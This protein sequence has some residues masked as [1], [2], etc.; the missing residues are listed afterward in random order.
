MKNLVAASLFFFGLVLSGF[1]GAGEPAESGSADAP[2]GTLDVGA[3]THL[4]GVLKASRAD[5]S[6]KLLSVKSD[7]LQGD[8]LTTEKDT[9]AR[10]KFND[11]GEIVLRPNTIF[12]VQRYSYDPIQR[13]E[14][15]I[16]VSLIKGGLRSVTGLIGKRSPHKYQMNTPVA[17]IGI[18]G[19]HFGALLCNDDCADIP[20]VA[21][22]TPENGLHTDTVQGATVVSNDRGSVDVPAGAFSYTASAGTQPKLVPPDQGIQITM[23]ASISNNRDNGNGV[24]DSKESSCSVK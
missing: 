3:I 19:T 7:V 20:T 14:D 12:K 15:N 9:Y 22:H 11:G 16:V 21:G 13:S 10:I 17:T 6:T 8:T 24:G 18:R 2:S 4:S 23:P 5:G 1:A